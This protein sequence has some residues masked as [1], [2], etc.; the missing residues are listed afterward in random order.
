MLTL[1]FFLDDV[2]LIHEQVAAFLGIFR[3]FILPGY[4]A[5]LMLY[6]TAYHS[7]IR[8]TDYSL[9]GISMFFFAVSLTIDL[10]QLGF[11]DPVLFGMV[12]KMI[13]IVSWMVYFFR[14][15]KNALLTPTI[16]IANKRDGVS[17]EIPHYHYN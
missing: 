16:P 6:L 8:R 11:F 9:L 3:I 13:G 12:A 1:I 4:G 15:A 17:N 14:L 2:F 7:L 10:M 5:F